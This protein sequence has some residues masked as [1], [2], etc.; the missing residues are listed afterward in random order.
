MISTREC[1]NQLV[2]DVFWQMRADLK[3]ERFEGGVSEEAQG[4][5]NTK[6]LIRSNFGV[7]NLY[8]KSLEN[9]GR[10][11]YIDDYWGMLRWMESLVPS[12]SRSKLLAIVDE[13]LSNLP[14]GSKPSSSSPS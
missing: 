2:H 13:F 10:D 7:S 5:A 12:D 3:V 4:W 9:M 11:V 1:F 6:D 14:Q 8:T